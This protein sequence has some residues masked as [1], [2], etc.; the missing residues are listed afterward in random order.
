MM[1]VMHQIMAIASM[2]V[3]MHQIMAIAVLLLLTMMHPRFQHTQQ[4]LLC[5][6]PTATTPSN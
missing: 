4:Q 2:M 5:D 3:V 1:V 6:E